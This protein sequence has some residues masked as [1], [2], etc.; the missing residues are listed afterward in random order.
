MIVIVILWQGELPWAPLA[1]H[2]A[3]ASEPPRADGATDA[4]CISLSL[5]IYIYMCVYM[6]VCMYIDIYMYICIHMYVYIYIYTYIY[7]YIYTYTYTYT[8]T[9]TSYSIPSTAPAAPAGWR[10]SGSTP[11]PRASITS[12]RLQYSEL[13]K[14]GHMTTGQ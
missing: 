2:A 3:P 9:S 12:A 13:H 14:Q 8:D 5:Y 10:S 1:Q 6:Y 7:I 4:V 11:R